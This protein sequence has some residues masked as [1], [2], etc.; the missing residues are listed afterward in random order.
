M[1]DPVIG[2]LAEALVTQLATVTEANGYNVTLSS[3]ARETRKGDNPRHLLAIVRQD[4]G[5]EAGVE[6]GQGQAI[7]TMPVIFI[8]KVYVQPSDRDVTPIDRLLN[9]VW[10]DI[11]KAL[12]S[13]WNDEAQSLGSLAYNWTVLAP[14]VFETDDRFNQILCRYAAFVRFNESDP[15]TQR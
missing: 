15:Y 3:V 7:V 11:T 4:Y 6:Q 10:A 1:A 9:I 5:D 14:E 13:V 8:V 2:N 12:A